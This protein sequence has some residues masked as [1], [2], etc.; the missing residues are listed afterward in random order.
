[1]NFPMYFIIRMRSL[2]YKKEKRKSIDKNETNSHLDLDLDLIDEYISKGIVDYNFIQDNYILKMENQLLNNL[3]LIIK[4]QIIPTNTDIKN[5]TIDDYIRNIES[6][7]NS[8]SEENVQKTSTLTYNLINI[9]DMLDTFESICTSP[10]HIMKFQ[11][12]ILYCIY[13]NEEIRN[14][15]IHMICFKS[16]IKQQTIKRTNLYKLLHQIFNPDVKHPYSIY[17]LINGNNFFD[18][19]LCTILDFNFCYE[20]NIEDFM[21]LQ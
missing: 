17:R 13:V 14:N 7:N 3:L 9:K 15:V 10:E 8:K 5:I 20:S 21:D 11:L 12:F 6:L 19:V 18:T 2:K 4:N 16:D 1:M